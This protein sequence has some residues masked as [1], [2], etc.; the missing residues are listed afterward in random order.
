MCTLRKGVASLLGISA[1]SGVGEPR[2]FERS[3]LSSK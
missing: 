3:E 2:I 1:A